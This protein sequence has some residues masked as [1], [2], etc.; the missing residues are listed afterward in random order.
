MAPRNPERVVLLGGSGFFGKA[1]TGL[2]QASSIDTLAL[3]SSMLDL[4]GDQAQAKLKEILRPSDSLVIL[5][6]LTP[7]RG[8]GIDTFM[9]NL[10]MMENICGVLAQ[11]APAHV[12]YFSSDA[13][14]PFGHGLINEHSPA[15]PA[16]LYGA[17]HRSREL[18]LS[19]VL[20]GDVCILRPTLV[21]GADDTHNSYGPNRFRRQAA[22]EKKIIL[23]GEGEETRDHVHI[24]D[25]AEI[26][27]RVL[28]RQSR[29]ILNIAT[30]RS[31]DFGS[32]ARLVA[33]RYAGAVEVCFSPRH[34]PVTH[35]A[36]DTTA[37]LKAFPGYVFTPLEKGLA[38]AQGDR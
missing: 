12:V 29:G 15:A 23:G 38:P 31:M 27:L 21:Y 16:D 19:Q 22:H 30:G 3:S 7:D 14:Y 26:T 8:R 25:L 34:S 11:A 35:R 18:M 33:A 13:V 28:A 37:L 1:I 24:S 2:L 4:C 10:K 5:S 20:S 36:F 6:A 17:M 32:V 9:A